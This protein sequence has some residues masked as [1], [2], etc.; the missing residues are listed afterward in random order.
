MQIKH[1]AI[2]RLFGE[3]VRTLRKARGLSQENLATTSGLDR[4]YIGGVERGE[5]NISL[6]NIHKICTALEISLQEM[7]EVINE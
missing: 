7:F 3:K 2:T 4:T 6:V 5:R 1:T